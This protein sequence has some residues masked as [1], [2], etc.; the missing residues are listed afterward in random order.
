MVRSIS[1]SSSTWPVSVVSVVV[2]VVVVYVLLAGQQ[3]SQVGA[4]AAAPPPLAASVS[5][6]RSVTVSCRVALGGLVV[7]VCAC[8]VCV[9]VCLLSVSECQS[10]SVSQFTA[11]SLPAWSPLPHFYPGQALHTSRAVW[12]R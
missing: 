2:V 9:V 11:L 4:A 10:S 12:C 3:L 7:C 6:G 5:V 1:S 8:V